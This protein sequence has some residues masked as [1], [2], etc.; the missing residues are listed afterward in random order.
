MNVPDN[1]DR[2]EQYEAEQERKLA[3]LPKCDKCGEPI[4]QERA[5]YYNDQWICEYCEED[6][7][8]EIREDFLAY[9]YED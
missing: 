3:R 9:T 8:R 5:V 2:F 1:Y 6:F 4:Q 7:W